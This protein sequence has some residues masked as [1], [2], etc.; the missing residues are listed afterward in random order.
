MHF[1][2][3]R[4]FCGAQFR[5]C[6]CGLQWG[7]RN[8]VL[9]QIYGNKQ[10]SLEQERNWNWTSWNRNHELVVVV[11]IQVRFKCHTQG[12]SLPVRVIFCFETPFINSRK[13]VSIKEMNI[14]DWCFYYFMVNIKHRVTSLSR[15]ALCTFHDPC[16]MM[17]ISTLKGS[18]DLCC[19]HVFAVIIR[20]ILKKYHLTS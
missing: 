17:Y 2:P 20:F 3:F 16:S 8:F 5:L 13:K 4:W 11:V 1:W 14:I 10:F 6:V 12:T 15:L 7:N 9:M 19:H 18:P